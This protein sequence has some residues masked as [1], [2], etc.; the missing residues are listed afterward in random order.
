M[1]VSLIDTG[2]WRNIGERLWAVRSHIEKDEIFLA[3]YSD[4]LSNVNLNEMIDIFRKSGKVACFMAVRPPL[5]FHLVDMTPEGRVKQL[6]PSGRVRHLDQRR[7]FPDA[8]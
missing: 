3:N 7:L 5:T 2:I 4:G 8:A 1:N 6:R